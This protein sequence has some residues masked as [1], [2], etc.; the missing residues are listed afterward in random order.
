VRNNPVLEVC[1]VRL[2]VVHSGSILVRPLKVRADLVNAATRLHLS[3]GSSL[4]ANPC[5]SRWLARRHRASNKLWKAS[6]R[7]AIRCVPGPAKKAWRGPRAHA[8]TTERGRRHVRSHW[9][10]VLPRAVPN[11]AAPAHMWRVRPK[12]QP[13]HTRDWHVVQCRAPPA[14]TRTLWHCL[15]RSA[16]L[17]HPIRC[18]LLAQAHAHSHTPSSIS[19][20]AR[21][22]SDLLSSSG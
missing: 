2:R 16:A 14:A 12:A 19:Q 13:Q 21:A 3:R 10:L 6:P 15:L 9:P 5:P 4:R 11:A 18:E 17:S 7:C 1:C 20:V 22:G 8:W